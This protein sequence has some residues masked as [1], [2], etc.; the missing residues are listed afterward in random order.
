MFNVY[1]DGQLLYCP[2]D[3]GLVIT[4]PT[5]TLE[6]GKAGSFQFDLPPTNPFYNSLKKIKMVIS[7]EQDGEEIFRGRVLSEERNFN[8]IKSVYCEGDLAYLSD[9]LQQGFAYEGTTHELFQQIIANH[10]ARMEEEKQF[11]VGTIGVEDRDIIVSGQS[12]DEGDPEEGF[13]FKQIAINSITNDYQTTYEYIEANLLDYCGGYLRTRRVDGVNYIDWLSADGNGEA[14]QTIEFGSNLLDLT[15]SI[16]AEELFTV[17]IPLGDD[18]LTIESVNNGS[19]ELVDEDLVAEYGRII[20][21]NVFD[22]VSKPETL[23]ENAQRYMAEKANVPITLSLTAVDMH[24]VDQDITSIRLNDSVLIRSAPHGLNKRL[25]CTKIE[26]PLD[27]PASSVYTFG[28]EIQSLTERYRKDKSASK[29]S[30]GSG[31]EDTSSSVGNKIYKAYINTDPETGHIDLRTVYEEYQN[32]KLTLRNEVGIDLDAPNGELNLVNLKQKQDEQGKMILQQSAQI[33]TINNDNKT[34]IELISSRVSVT[35]EVLDETVVP[36]MDKLKSD[37]DDMQLTLDEHETEIKDVKTTENAHYASLTLTTTDLQSQ[38]DA[39]ADQITLTTASDEM[40]EYTDAQY[41]E[42]KL[43]T[44]ENG[45]NITMKA[46][47]VY[48]DAQITEVKNLIA[49]TVQAELAGLDSLVVTGSIS[50]GSASVSGDI[51]LSGTVYATGNVQCNT[52]IPTYCKIGST[53]YTVSR[54]T[55]RPITSLDVTTKTIS[56]TDAHGEVASVTVVTGVS[57]GTP[58]VLSYLALST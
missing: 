6:R 27:D 37:R 54:K 32:A 35:E 26:L 20:K 42:L 50:A 4:S 55:S 15:E 5:L 17:L 36:D 19:D 30:G 18:N 57:G 23:L 13:D 29:G 7:V 12:D 44:G 45:A 48:V 34:S 31:E 21:T 1:A 33:N 43:Y 52:I 24:L 49:E 8:N 22:N 53:K 11:T 25:V 9:S 58:A 41:A 10:N 46:N 47:K 16:N 51:E 14:S 39:K 2:D 56:Y 40:K 28:S 3:A 38:I